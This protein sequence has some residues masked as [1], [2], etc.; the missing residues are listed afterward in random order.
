MHK[1]RFIPIAV[2]L[3]SIHIGLMHTATYFVFNRLISH[4]ESRRLSQNMFVISYPFIFMGLM[5]SK[6]NSVFVFCNVLVEM[7]K[8]PVIVYIVYKVY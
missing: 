3:L 8:C 7:L 4:A 6:N 2:S 1:A 5:I